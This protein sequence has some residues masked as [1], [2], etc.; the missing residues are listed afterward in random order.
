MRRRSAE[1]DDGMGFM[2][3]AVAAESETIRLFLQEVLSMP[4][5]CRQV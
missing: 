3:G 2:P 4:A 1:P 5:R